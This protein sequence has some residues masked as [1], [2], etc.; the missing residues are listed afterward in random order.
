MNSSAIPNIITSTRIALVIPVVWSL[1]EE[2]YLTAIAL[3]FVAGITDALDGFIAKKFGWVTRLGAILDPLADKV[4]LVA[5]YLVLGWND[6][7]PV[8]L[9]ALVIAR[10]LVIVIG[11]ALYN[12]RIRKVDLAPSLISKIN[13]AAQII[14]V[15]VVVIGQVWPQILNSIQMSLILVVAFTTLSS[16]VSYIWVW[17]RRAIR[18]VKGSDVI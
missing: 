4:L 8:W 10:D 6:L 12:K 7:L 18:E 9:V 14:L 3:F 5:S 1:I 15:L 17:G 11:F 16:G 2:R 13:T